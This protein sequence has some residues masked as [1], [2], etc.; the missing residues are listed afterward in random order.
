MSPPMSKQGIDVQFEF[1]LQFRLTTLTCFD[2]LI[3]AHFT[4]SFMPSHFFVLSSNQLAPM[5]TRSLR[6]N[7]CS[8]FLCVEKRTGKL[9]WTASSMKNSKGQK[10]Q[11]PEREI[12]YKSQWREK[13]KPKPK[14]NRIPGTVTYSERAEAPPCWHHDL[15]C[16]SLCRCTRRPCSAK[17]PVVPTND[18]TRWFPRW[19]CDVVR[20]PGERWKNTNSSQWIFLK[21]G[22]QTGFKCIVCLAL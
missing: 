6:G 4:Q 14:K 12:V 20:Y 10:Q 18:P 21:K 3:R 22:F 15:R 8:Q 7:F 16:W 2:T 9:I 19:R 1:T 5:Y 11:F 17:R 13:W